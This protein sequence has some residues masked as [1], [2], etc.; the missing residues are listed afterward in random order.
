MFDD[1]FEA[2]VVK[3]STGALDECIEMKTVSEEEVSVVNLDRP[4]TVTDPSLF[5][6]SVGV[7]AEDGF[8]IAVVESSEFGHGNELTTEF[9]GSKEPHDITREH[10]LD[11]ALAT[12]FD[13]PER[14]LAVAEVNAISHTEDEVNGFSGFRVFIGVV[15]C[16]GGGRS[17]G[18][19]RGVGH[20]EKMVKVIR[21]QEV[22][23]SFVRMVSRFAG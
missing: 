6:I 3:H 11:H 2:M 1:M 17:R 14:E 8:I 16:S 23:E 10:F 18:K 4:A 9:L 22:F 5:S 21:A 12:V 15:E 19:E 20:D 7:N 13:T